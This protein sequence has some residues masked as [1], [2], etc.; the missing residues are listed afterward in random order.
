[1]RTVIWQSLIA[2]FYCAIIVNKKTGNR[3]RV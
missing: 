3:A 1:M 2:V